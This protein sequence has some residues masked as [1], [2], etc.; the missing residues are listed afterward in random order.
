MSQSSRPPFHNLSRATRGYHLTAL[1]L[2]FLTALAT[3]AVYPQLPSV[4]PAHWDV[5]GHT[6]SFA[7]KWALFLYTPCLMIGIVSMFIALPRLSPRRFETNSLRPSYLYVLLVILSLLTYSQ[8]LVLL[9]G[10]GGNVDVS[11]AVSGGLAL[12][13]ALFG[14]RALVAAW[15]G[16]LAESRK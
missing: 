14:S 3:F 15:K 8:L 9:S 11:Q 6:N 1:A 12:L 16:K 7:P 13:L 10:L 2:I 4:V 5:D